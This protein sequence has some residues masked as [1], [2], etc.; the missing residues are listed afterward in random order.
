MRLSQGNWE[1]RQVMQQ[2]E[3]E[4]KRKENT[5]AKKRNRDIN[6]EGERYPPTEKNGIRQK[7]RDSEKETERQ[8]RD[9]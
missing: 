2:G 8:K 6:R 3:G 9:I 4:R 1:D 7:V 5:E